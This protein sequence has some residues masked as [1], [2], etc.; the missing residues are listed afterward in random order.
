MR[1]FPSQL[2]PAT[3]G[4]DVEVPANYPGVDGASRHSTDDARRRAAILRAHASDCENAAVGHAEINVGGCRSD[5]GA[6][7]AD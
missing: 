4:F 7:A 2:L 3:P 6:P 5:S 1:I